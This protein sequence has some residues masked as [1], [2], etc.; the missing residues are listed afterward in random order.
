MLRRP[1]SDRVS[2]FSSPLFPELNA[3]ERMA[4]QD[5]DPA[6]LGYAFMSS[7]FIDPINDGLLQ[8]STFSGLERMGVHEVETSA[9][10]TTRSRSQE[11][12]SVTDL[13]TW[14]WGRCC[15]HAPGGIRR[16]SLLVGRNACLGGPS[17][18]LPISF[19]ISH[20]WFRKDGCADYSCMTEGVHDEGSDGQDAQDHIS[21]ERYN[22]NIRC[23][24]KY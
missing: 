11:M 20:L 24:P 16:G 18:C 15:R 10:F 6:S 1:M 3:L 9:G 23:H 8:Q 12:V 13:G 19:L 22:Y 21:A 17:V 5:V 14:G 2:S 7:E 4:V